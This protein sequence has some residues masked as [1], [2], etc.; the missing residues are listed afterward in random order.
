MNTRKIRI[1]FEVD[2]S[3]YAARLHELL[4]LALLEEDFTMLKRLRTFARVFDIKVI[5]QVVSPE[6]QQ[7]TLD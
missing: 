6:D 3:L 7:P 5:D 4:C 2:E 1:Y